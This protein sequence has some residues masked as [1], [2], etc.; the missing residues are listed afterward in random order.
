MGEKPTVILV[1]ETWV[2]SAKRDLFSVV[3]AFAIIG[4]G[5]ALNSSAMQWFGFLLLMI[6]TYSRAAGLRKRMSMSPDEAIEKINQIKE[7]I[8]AD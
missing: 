4:P 5:I 7:R 3:C 1:E 8:D 2:E 6:V